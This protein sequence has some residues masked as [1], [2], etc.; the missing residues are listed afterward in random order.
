MDVEGAR[1]ESNAQLGKD[2]KESRDERRNLITSTSHVECLSFIRSSWLFLKEQIPVSIRLDA[3]APTTIKTT[4]CW[5]DYIARN[6]RKGPLRGISLQLHNT[7]PSF[8]DFLQLSFVLTSIPTWH[9]TTWLPHHQRRHPAG[10]LT[11]PSCSPR[12]C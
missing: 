1:F 6:T 2:G 9:V 7:T 3:W 10:D 11:M 5:S 8:R 12:S 4:G